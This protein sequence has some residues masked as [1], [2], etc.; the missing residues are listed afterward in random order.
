MAVAPTERRYHSTALLLPDGSVMKAGSTGGFAGPETIV[1]QFGIDK[2]EPP[3]LW[4][5]PRPSV[6]SQSTTSA[7]HGGSFSMSVQSTDGAPYRVALLRFGSVTHGLD[8]DQRCVFLASSSTGAPSG[9]ETV[10]AQIP[11]HAS[12]TPPGD[13]MLFVVDRHGVPSQARFLRVIP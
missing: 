13:Y 3:Y 7:P 8:M 4:R 12:V 10:T 11:L 2:F 5:G 1:P 9:G 6:L